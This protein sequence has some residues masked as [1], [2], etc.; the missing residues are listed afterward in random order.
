MTIDGVDRGIA[1]L[2]A[3]VNAGHHTVAVSGSESYAFPSTGVVVTSRDT[4]RVLFR[5][6]RTQ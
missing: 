3:F 5:S 2:T 6:A 4:V 1:P